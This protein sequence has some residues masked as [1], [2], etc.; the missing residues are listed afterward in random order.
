[1][2]GAVVMQHGDDKGLVMPPNIAPTQI[3][4]VPILFEKTRASTLEAAQKAAEWLKE[5]RV[6]IDSRDEYSAGWKFNDWEMKG[7]PLRIEV[8][9]KDIENKRVVMVRRDTGE[10]ITAKYNE[11]ASKTKELLEDIQNNLFTKAKENLKKALVEVDTW[12]EFMKAVDNKKAI[13]APFCG[14]VACE[15]E[16]KEKTKGANSRCRPF[17]QKNPKKNCVHCGKPAHAYYYFGKCY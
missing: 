6:E 2:I 9:P 17:D 1:L 13:F 16:I 12:P 8:G 11:I 15:D 4:I 5:F 7:V 14:G 3:V 10:K